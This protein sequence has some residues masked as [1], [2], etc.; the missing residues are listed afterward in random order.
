MEVAGLSVGV[1][2]LAGFCSNCLEAFDLIGLAK[3]FSIDAE[4][5]SIKLDIEKTR[6]LQWAEGIELLAEDQREQRATLRSPELQPQIERILLAVRSLLTKSEDLRAKYG[7]CED[8]SG[9]RQATAN[10]LSRVSSARSRSFQ[11][12]FAG[13]QRRIS[14]NQKNASTSTKTIWAVK[15][16]KKFED[17]IRNLHQLISGL[18]DLVTIPR[19]FRRL[20]VEK[21]VN[22]L[23][24]DLSH[25][26][27][28]EAAS[29][30]LDDRD[31]VELTSLRVE[32]S[33][34]ASQDFRTLE[35]W[36]D[37]IESEDAEIEPAYH[38]QISTQAQGVDTAPFNYLFPIDAK[39]WHQTYENWKFRGKSLEIADCLRWIE[40]LRFSDFDRRLELSEVQTVFELMRSTLDAVHD[41]WVLDPKSHHMAGAKVRTAD[42]VSIR[43]AIQAYQAKSSIYYTLANKDTGQT[44]S[45]ISSTALRQKHMMYRE[46]KGNT[47]FGLLSSLYQDKMIHR[48]SDSS[49][50]TF[51]IYISNSSRD[52]VLHTITIYDTILWWT[53]SAVTTLLREDPENL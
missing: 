18:I 4:I 45:R 2:A 43:S 24:D 9:L 16:H 10:T 39:A 48:S 12:A 15:D 36:L 3:D 33:Q 40:L 29:K 31:W 53:A 41:E 5:L 30:G 42:L 1:I 21:D 14:R 52:N 23:T 17:L 11:I 38:Q 25:L 28:Y 37:D 19:T 8:E 13:F 50:Q 47:H 51:K 22:S 7:L 20:M 46:K 27:L 6:L 35:E 44:I 34:K 26:R 49:V 32:A